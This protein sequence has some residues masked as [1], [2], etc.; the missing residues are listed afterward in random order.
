[1]EHTRDHIIFFMAQ[2]MYALEQS[3][4]REAFNRLV[5]HFEQINLDGLLEYLT[6]YYAVDVDR[7]M[8]DFGLVEGELIFVS[9]ARGYR[10][11]HVYRDST[12]VRLRPHRPPLGRGSTPPR[13]AQ[14]GRSSRFSCRS[15][16][17]RISSRNPLAMPVAHVSA[18]NCGTSTQKPALRLR[19]S[20]IRRMASCRP[21]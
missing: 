9:R 12:T 16:T 11:K 4:S 15:Y 7:E 2:K 8:D 18:L 6:R 20:S 10:F 3:G 13:S 19:S 1:M 5:E 14:A 17:P 21:S